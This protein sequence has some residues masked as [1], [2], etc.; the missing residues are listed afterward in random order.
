MPPVTT[1]S[2]SIPITLPFTAQPFVV[3]S[4]HKPNQQLDDPTVS[5]PF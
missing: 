5:F 4:S 2:R 3:L 1:T